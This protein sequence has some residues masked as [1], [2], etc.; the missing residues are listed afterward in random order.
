M[1]AAD[2]LRAAT[3]N[4]VALALEASSFGHWPQDEAELLEVFI[5]MIDAKLGGPGQME[6]RR[7][8]RRELN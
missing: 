4:D 6:M 1:T 3:E 7:N 8:L 5:R 2:A